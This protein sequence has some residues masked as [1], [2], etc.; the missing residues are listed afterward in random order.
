M[1]KDK[2]NVELETVE[3][4]VHYK[5][6]LKTAADLDARFFRGKV[7]VKSGSSEMPVKEIFFHGWVKKG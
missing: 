2:I 6:H 5:I 3:D 4:G 1:H 7:L